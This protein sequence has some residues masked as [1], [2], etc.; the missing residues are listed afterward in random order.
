MNTQIATLAAGRVIFH[1]LSRPAAFPYTAHPGGAFA[2]KIAPIYPVVRSLKWPVG[3]A[4]T[5]ADA[6]DLGDRMLVWIASEI[7][8]A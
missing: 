6:S 2:R 8:T 3:P 4:L 7:G 1:L 5:D